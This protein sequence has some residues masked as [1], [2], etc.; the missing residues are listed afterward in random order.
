V[1]AALFFLV[2]LG[3]A[4]LQGSRALSRSGIE[5]DKHEVPP[6]FAK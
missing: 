2:A 1:F 3:Y 6:S 5:Q 4:L